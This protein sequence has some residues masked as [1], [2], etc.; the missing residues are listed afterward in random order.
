MAGTWTPAKASDVRAGDRIRLYGMELDVTRVDA[1][2]LGR[3]EMVCFVESTEERW[4]C[5]PA[6]VEGDVE[7]LR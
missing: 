7:V 5:L 1:P 6:S 3:A 4:A 2:F